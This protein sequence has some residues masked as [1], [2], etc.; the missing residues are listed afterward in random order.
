MPRRPDREETGL[1]ARKRSA[2]KW[3]ISKLVAEK[4][5]DGKRKT[6]KGIQDRTSKDCWGTRTNSVVGSKTRDCVW[7]TN[8]ENRRLGKYPKISGSQ[9][10]PDAQKREKPS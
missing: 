9:A 7:G 5:A 3:P 8:A 1:N 10:A 2:E 6:G 4:N